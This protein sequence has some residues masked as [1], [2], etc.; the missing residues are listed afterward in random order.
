[1]ADPSGPAP[2]RP[3]AP[4]PSRW[5]GLPWVWAIPAIALVIAAWLGVRALAERGPTVT[6]SFDTA[7]G[8]ES[9]RTT[10]RYKNV[11][12]GRVTGIGLSADRSRA[13]V[14]ATMQRAAE[15]LLRAD[16]KFWVVRPRVGLG[17]IS[18]LTTVLSGAYVG[19]LPGKG[20][21]GARTF[22]GL[23]TPPPKEG[24]AQ[25]HEF[26]LIADRLPGI[27]DQSP[28]YFHGVQV[29]EV[30]GHKLS[31]RDGTVAV[32]IFIYA[33]HQSLIRS[34]S[35][36][37]VASGVQLSFGAQGLKIGTEPLLSLLAGGVVFDTPE[38]ELAAAPAAIGATFRLYADEK[39]ADAAADPVRVSYRL[40]FPGSVRG[41]EIGTPV[42]LRGIPI[43]QVSAVQL[44]YDR[45][46]DAIR[47]PV[48]IKIA[49]HLI[50]IAG[51]PTPPPA[52]QDEAAATNRLLGHL[53][54]R[55]LRAQLATGNL[56][57]GQRL[58]ELDFAKD[59]P[60]A[61]M[62]GG[63]PYPELPTIGGS[64]LAEMAG[65]ATKLLDKLA[66]L[67]LDQLIAQIRGMVG[68]ADSLI[69]APQLKRSLRN[70]DLTL[71]NAE[72]MTRTA[73]TQIG[74]LLGRLNAAA[75]QLK[76]TLTLLG[77][78]PRSSADLAHTLAELKDA[79]R[80]VKVLADFLE[81][82]PESLLR[83]KPQEASK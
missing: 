16:T 28:V 20:A 60:P 15:P 3:P 17:G 55:G 36:F 67:P 68:H 50:A 18:G 51:E 69:D 39:A 19:M 78:D 33:P 47:V 77:N 59:A 64:G 7:E 81:R 57:T 73:Q 41:V 66:Q 14:T 4:Q 74:P 37:W 53:V 82:H 48:T 56:L 83:G 76:A 13:V 75:D 22:S 21:P 8:L 1:M 70:L 24:L 29:G 12:L 72:R 58:I 80:S 49:P 10:I 65:A 9:D 23:D 31:D 43:G 61:Q 2:E 54:A 63:E 62:G 46:T 44:E 27:S 6:I 45:A 25:G 40:F 42:D 30:T 38:H 26:T 71:A 79:A 11:E 35:R 34:D 5:A 32:H 52:H